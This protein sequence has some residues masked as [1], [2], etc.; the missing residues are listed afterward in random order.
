MRVSRQTANGSTGC[1]RLQKSGAGEGLCLPEW[2]QVRAELKTKATFIIRAKAGSCMAATWCRVQPGRG[3]MAPVVCVRTQILSLKA[4]KIVTGNGDWGQPGNR[5][6]ICPTKPSRSQNKT[7]SSL[8]HSHNTPQKTSC[9]LNIK[10]LMHELKGL[11]H[12]STVNIFNTK[13]LSAKHKE[14]KQSTMW[15]ASALKVFC[16]KNTVF[17]LSTDL[18]NTYSELKYFSVEDESQLHFSWSANKSNAH[19]F[20]NK[21]YK[22]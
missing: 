2:P 10:H 5:D 1:P 12:K 11:S 16:F 14:F 13:K 8:R 20:S 6:G 18:V 21:Q 7:A 9:H 17:Q 4:L 19:K 3:L 15:G 22:C